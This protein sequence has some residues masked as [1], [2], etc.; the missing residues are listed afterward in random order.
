MLGFYSMLLLP[1]K[2]QNI[3]LV[4]EIGMFLFI[5]HP[6]FVVVGGGFVI[7]ENIFAFPCE[8]TFNPAKWG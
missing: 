2:W 6:S 4:V 1:Q 7:H 5:P 3:F 8:E